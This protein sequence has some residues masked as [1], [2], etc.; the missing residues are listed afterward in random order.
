MSRKSPKSI[1][2]PKVNQSSFGNSQKIAQLL[3]HGFA[4]HSSGKINEARLI[5][6]EIL[7]YQSNHFDALQL[8]A[9]TYAQ[10]E[11]PDFALK[12]F[13]LALQINKTDPI[14]FNNKGIALQQLNRLDEALKS[15]EQAL[16]IKPDYIENIFLLMKLVS[17]PEVYEHYD[18]AFNEAN[19]RYGDMK[20]QLAEDMIGFIAPI[21]EKSTTI[22]ADEKYLKG[23][24]E[25]GAEMAGE[26]ASKTMKVVREAIGLNYY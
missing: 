10:Q 14:I 11:K 7:I 5:Y 9:T 17:T 12:Y 21:R 15:Y 23:I 3:D 24:M 18:K 22:L 20:K 16:H 1:N 19:I 2:K 8:L 13:D 6:E 4:L 26:S 25:K